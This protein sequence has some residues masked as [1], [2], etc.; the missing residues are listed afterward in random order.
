MKTFVSRQGL[1]GLR[2]AAAWAS[3][4]MCMVAS[5]A[6]AQANRPAAAPANRPAANAAPA[7]GAQTFLIGTFNDWRALTTGK[8]K[9]KMCYALSEPKERLPKALKRDPGYLFIS[10]RAADGARNE[11]AFKLGFATKNG[12]DGTL[13]VGTATFALVASGESAFLKNPAQEAQLIEQMKRAQSISIKVASAR[14]NETT[15]RYSM[16][17]FARAIEAVAKECP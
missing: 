5:G 13:S 8:D 17:G 6:Q 1:V 4:A 3:L 11:V 2:I 10:T 12:Q 16:N 14:G 9:Q 7:G 15:D